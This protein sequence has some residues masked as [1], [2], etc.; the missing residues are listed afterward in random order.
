MSRSVN[1]K[2]PESGEKFFFSNFSSVTQPD[3]TKYYKDQYGD[4]MVN[5]ANGVDLEFI[6]KENVD[7]SSIGI[8]GTAEDR[9]KK[10]SEHYKNVAEKYNKSD[11]VEEIKFKAIEREIS[12]EAAEINQKI[13]NSKKSKENV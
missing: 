1:F 4:R 13:E 11:E 6:P 3:G 7:Y 2:C 10:D 12:T 5:P 8:S 9:W